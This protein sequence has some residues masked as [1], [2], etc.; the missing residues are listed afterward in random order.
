MT[1]PLRVGLVLAVSC[2]LCGLG[3]AATQEDEDACRP[4]VFRLCASAIPDEPAIVACL[5]ANLPSL[6]AAC[7][8]VIDP[9]RQGSRA[10][11]RSR[12]AQGLQERTPALR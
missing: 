11:P 6:G 3:R 9:P 8:R 1:A 10:T 7:R 2:L 12:G 4:D 5:N